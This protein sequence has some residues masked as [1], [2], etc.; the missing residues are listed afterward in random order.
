MQ[1]ANKP[2]TLPIPRS[3]II[4]IR[5]TKLGIVCIMSKTGK[6][7]FSTLLDFDISTPIGI[8]T[9]IQTNVETDIIATVAIQFFHIPK[10]PIIMKQTIVPITSLTLLEPIHA[11]KANT[12]ITKGQGLLT[13]NFSNQIKK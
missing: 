4:G 12:P 8:P 3:I 9:T 6:I 10:Y 11:S 2:G 1:T 5:Y 7:D 13:N